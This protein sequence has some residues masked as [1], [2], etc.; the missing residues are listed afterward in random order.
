MGA[1]TRGNGD[2][3]KQAVLC[4][5]SRSPSFSLALE[6]E[7][8]IQVEEIQWRHR[9]SPAYKNACV[10]RQIHLHAKSL[11]AQILFFFFI[12]ALQVVVVAWR[13]YG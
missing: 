1:G 6:I 3:I 13:R 11:L 5:M 4:A 10:S 9:C 2:A 12:F 7:D 8:E